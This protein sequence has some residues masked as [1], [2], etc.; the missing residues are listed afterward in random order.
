MNGDAA[1][2]V[3]SFYQIF[4]HLGL[5][6]EVGSAA[7]SVH[8]LKFVGVQNQIWPKVSSPF[9]GGGE[10]YKFHSCSSKT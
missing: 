1:E 8:F 3:F 7:S 4:L 2:G 9:S 10:A 6:E 5:G